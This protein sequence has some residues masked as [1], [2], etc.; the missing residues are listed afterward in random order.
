MISR[1]PAEPLCRH[2]RS[3]G[4]AGTGLCGVFE[5]NGINIA[6]PRH[7]VNS[8]NLSVA[9]MVNQ[10]LTTGG[11]LT[12]SIKGGQGIDN[13]IGSHE[14]S[15]A[16][17]VELMDMVSFGYVGDI[18]REPSHHLG[19][20]AVCRKEKIDAER[21]ITA[22]HQCAALWKRGF[23]ALESVD[24]PRSATHYA[25]ALPQSLADI[26][27]GNRRNGKLYS[28]VGRTKFRRVN[29]DMCILIN[30]GHNFMSSTTGHLFDNM[31]H[32]TISNQSYFHRL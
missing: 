31:T 9:D 13:L 8:G 18:L 17:M 6:L 12:P 16:G 23:Y 10:E 19:N 20:K 27:L 29:L 30:Y 3:E 32:L 15:A 2:D 1:L 5:S 14:S 11:F 28:Y 24:P 21:I 25:D 22:P 26:G 4:E 7:P